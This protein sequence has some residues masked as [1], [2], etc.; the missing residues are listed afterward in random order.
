MKML[1]YRGIGLQ[2]SH[3]SAYNYVIQTIELSLCVRG[4]VTSF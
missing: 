4:K 1:D 3:Y 2:R